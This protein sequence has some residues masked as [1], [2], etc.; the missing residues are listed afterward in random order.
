MDRRRHVWNTFDAHRLLHWAGLEALG[1]QRALK[2]ALLRAYF[3]DGEN[4]SDHD[5]LA[6]LAESAG[7][8]GGRARQVLASGE[9]ADAVRERQRHY[10]GS[11]IT[12]VPS[13][14]FND[15]HLV[16]GGQPVEVFERA[17]R[18]L[19]AGAGWGVGCAA[20]VTGRAL[21][22]ALPTHDHAAPA[23]RRRT[24]AGCRPGS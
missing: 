4:V 18:Q 15:R 24:G 23:A 12:A 22:P 16:Q 21:A 20:V 10:T 3:T 14:I 11:G 17:L 9:F 8:D 1:K 7:L 6:R 2:H 13:V 19:A 5:V